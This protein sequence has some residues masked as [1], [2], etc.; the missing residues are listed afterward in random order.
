MLQDDRQA[1]KILDK[2]V[3]M[4]NGHYEVGMLWKSE[5]TWLPDKRNMAAAQLRTLK[6]KL[7]KNAELRGKYKAF[8]DD[9]LEKGYARKLIVEETARWTNKTWI[10]KILKERQKS[11]K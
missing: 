4:V 2:T 10:L 3:C 1:L 11:T 8:V 5:E 7:D 6:R 9:Y